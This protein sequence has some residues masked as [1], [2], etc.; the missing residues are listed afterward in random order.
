[1][2]QKMIE[3]QRR[4]RLA[5]DALSAVERM[6]EIASGGAHN[7]LGRSIREAAYAATRKKDQRD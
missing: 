2:N 3:L 5:K 7:D 6:L 1:M 4:I